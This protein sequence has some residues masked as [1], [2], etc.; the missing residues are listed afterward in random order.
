MA[1]LFELVVSKGT[2]I[3][4][5]GTVGAN[6]GFT[7][8]NDMRG[9]SLSG[10]SGD[11]VTFT[12][13]V[14]GV[15]TIIFG[16]KKAADS[17]IFLDA[18]ADKL[19]IT[20]G[21]ISG[22]GLTQNY[23]D[24]V[25]TNAVGDNVYH[26]V[27]A[28]FS[29]GIDFDTN[30]KIEPSSLIYLSDKIV[31]HDSILTAQER[32][33]EYSSFLNLSGLG[34][35][36]FP[37]YGVWGKA[38]DLSNVP[39]ILAAYNFTEGG[40]ETDVSGNGGNGVHGGSPLLTLAGKKLNGIDDKIALFIDAGLAA[41]VKTVVFRIKLDTTTEQILEGGAND[42]LIL[43]SAGTLTYTDYDNAFINGVDTN[44][45]VAGQWMNIVVTSSTAVD[46]ATAT[47]GLNDTT[48]GAFEIEDLKFYSEE[49][50][51][52]QAQAYHN[53]FAKRVVVRETF[54]YTP[55]SDSPSGIPRGYYIE[56][57]TFTVAEDSTSKYI[58]CGASG[59]ISL[60]GVGLDS[61]FENGWIKQID[62]DLSGDAE[63]TVDNATNVAYAGGKITFTMTTGQK[64]RN[65]IITEA[66]EQ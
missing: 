57:G 45:V 42:K 53:S 59:D 20:G 37:K 21:N 58:L 62:G 26:F 2:F 12:E 32:A 66:E 17:K 28:E 39:D 15:K 56:N 30:V 63:D 8:A 41:T 16:I 54:V 18:A 34:S 7:Y 40:R 48:F 1:K 4:K 19:E 52:A 5:R 61:Y 10:T 36:L 35:E 44:T 50:T 13:V 22:T 9:L 14:T 55:V 6:T 3:N 27:I 23:V 64:L 31:L 65:V 38:S 51:L 46:N 60:S 25:D 29:A 33:K 43:A 49:W 11:D 47:L 24:N